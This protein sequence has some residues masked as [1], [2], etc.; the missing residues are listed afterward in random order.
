MFHGASPLSL[1]P[2]TSN[3]I[4]S[5]TPRTPLGPINPNLV[6]VTTL[7]TPPDDSTKRG[8]HVEKNVNSTRTA[9]HLELCVLR[10]QHLRARLSGATSPK[11]EGGVITPRAKENTIV[12]GFEQREKSPLGVVPAVAE[13]GRNVNDQVEEMQKRV[14]TLE[15][16]RSEKITQLAN[17]EVG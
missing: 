1:G 6:D 4:A 3:A 15:E 10:S 7:V 8:T 14:K 12:L 9:S 13:N 17:L 16:V 5:R 11:E 2:I